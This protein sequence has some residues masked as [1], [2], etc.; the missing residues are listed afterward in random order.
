[1]SYFYPVPPVITGEVLS[2][3]PRDLWATKTTECIPGMDLSFCPAPES[4]FINDPKAQV[5]RR[6][7]S[8]RGRRPTPRVAFS[9]VDIPYGRILR[10]RI[11]SGEWTVLADYDGEPN[12]L[13][14]DDDGNLLVADCKN[15]IVRFTPLLSS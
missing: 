7:S 15:G 8:S 10:L 6:Q 14:L 1:M 9:W 5:S 13:T 4:P 2:S 3:V 11:S 12:G